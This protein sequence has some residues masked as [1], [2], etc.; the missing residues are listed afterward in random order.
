MKKQLKIAF[1]GPSGSG[2]S[3][4]AS[5]FRDFV[6]ENALDCA[7][8]K[9]AEPLYR[10]QAMI[11][12][13]AGQPIDYRSQDQTLLEMIAKKMRAIDKEALINNLRGRLKTCNADVIINDDLRDDIT[14]WPAM[15]ENDFQIV[16][17]W[18][19][20]QVRRQRLAGR[21]DLDAIMDSALD[22]QVTRIRPNFVVTNNSDQNSLKYQV[23]ALARQLCS[24]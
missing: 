17:I 13:E 16:R 3:T 9:L 11:Y 24:L 14:D 2:K 18:T 12:K 6:E 20:P 5:F 21:Q 7:V 19:E 15:I 22:E 1:V 8:L 4:T 23:H 10:V